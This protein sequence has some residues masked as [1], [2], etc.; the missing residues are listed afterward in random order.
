MN[1]FM[2]EKAF[3]KYR[4]GASDSDR[5]RYDFF[6]GLYRLLADRAG[7]TA[8]RFADPLPDRDELRAW[9]WSGRSLLE[10]D[11]LQVDR[12][13]FAQ[14]CNL[15][16]SYLAE[17]ASLEGRA[18]EELARFDWEAFCEKADLG[19]AGRDPAAFLD[20]SLAGIGSFGVSADLP[21]SLFAMVPYY[22]LRAHLD[23]PAQQ[24]A[25]AAD[26]AHDPSSHDHPLS[27]PFCGTPATVAVVGQA[28]GTDGNGRMLY[29]GQCGTTWSFERV[30][31]AHCGER[32]SQKLHYFHLEGDS[33]HRLH[34]CNSCGSY[35]RTVFQED[36]AVPLS[37]ETEDVVMAKLDKVALDP[38]F[39]K[40][41][42]R[43]EQ[44]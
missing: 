32:S 30:R 11:P 31:C 35:M 14:T 42:K 3:A 12:T 38:R 43:T 16:S 13:A 34:L 7:Q 17:N 29:C 24:A 33:A 44:R 36:L 25:K 15:V 40:E 23:G 27:C 37:P 1:L 8:D 18:A 41:G 5:A 20:S 21:A 22:A 6:E 9:H 39:R 10:H 19:L 2:I 26:M 28:A 4:E